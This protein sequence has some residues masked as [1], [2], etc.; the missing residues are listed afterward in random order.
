MEKTISMGRL[1]KRFDEPI[2]YEKIKSGYGNDLKAINDIA[3]NLQD[4]SDDN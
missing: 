4:T 2:S 3:E 1:K